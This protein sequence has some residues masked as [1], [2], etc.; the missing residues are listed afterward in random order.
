M[1]QYFAVTLQVISFKNNVY[2]LYGQSYRK[3]TLI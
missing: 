3:G 1:K 2:F